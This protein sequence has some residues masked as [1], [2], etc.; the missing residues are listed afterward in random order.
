MAA[1]QS[2]IVA[3]E[4]ERSTIVIKDTSCSSCAVSM[5]CEEFTCNICE[6][7]YHRVC[8][9]SEDK[10]GIAACFRCE[11]NGIQKSC[12]QVMLS[13][14]MEIRDLKYQQTRYEKLIIQKD[15]LIEKLVQ[16]ISKILPSN[17]VITNKNANVNKQAAVVPTANTKHNVHIGDTD[18]P[19]ISLRGQDGTVLPSQQVN[20]NILTNETEWKTV[21]RIRKR[22]KSSAFSG[23]STNSDLTLQICPKI[24]HKWL[25]VSRMGKDVTTQDMENYLKSKA[26]GDYIVEKLVPRMIDPNYSS[27]KVGVPLS[28]ADTVI[29]PAFWPS[30]VFVN[31]FYFKRDNSNKAVNFQVNS[32]DRPNS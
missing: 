10:F 8:A 23:T 9:K 12:L 30:K 2:V 17:Q 15:H 1:M 7:D 25:F 31:R 32:K 11:K 16:D 13:L 4:L 29:D 5:E 6:Q 14:K 21:N 3:G 18:K 20:A 24:S 22:K 19:T 26:S 27:F 28:V